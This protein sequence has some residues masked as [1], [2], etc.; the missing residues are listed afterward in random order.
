M[1][2][3]P[4]A[5]PPPSF[6]NQAQPP[7][8]QRPGELLDRFVARL[9]DIIIVTV[10][11]V[12]LAAVVAL[13][14]RSGFLRGIIDAILSAGLYLGYFSYMESTQGKTIG[15]TVMKLRVLGPA[16]GNPTMEQAIRRNI[17]TAF[18]IAGILP[19]LGAFIGA[20]AELVAVIMIAVGINSDTVNRQAWNDRFAG[21][22]RVVKE[23]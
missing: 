13:I 2:E 4:P 11:Y 10:V 1:S 9:L 6:D 8:G 23:T 21:G 5:P 15:K 12:V 7:T 3:M 20:V 22:T 17:W 19:I 18:G 16:G 14:I